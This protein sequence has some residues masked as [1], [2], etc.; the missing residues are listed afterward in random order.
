M[1]TSTLHKLI[2]LGAFVGIIYGFV[3]VTQAG[4][5]VGVVQNDGYAA[6][7][8]TLLLLSGLVLGYE[9]TRIKKK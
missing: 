1:K 8:G 3:L 7:G 4:Q 2:I 5:G 9:S 6:T